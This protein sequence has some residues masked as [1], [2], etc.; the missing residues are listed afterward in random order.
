[1]LKI[2]GTLVETTEGNPVYTSM[3]YE[4]DEETYKLVND[5]FDITY[6]FGAYNQV[7]NAENSFKKDQYAVYRK[8]AEI[9]KNQ[10]PVEIEKYSPNEMAET[11]AQKFEPVEVEVS[12]NSEDGEVKYQKNYGVNVV[13]P[14]M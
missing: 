9:T 3:L 14:E 11:S 2:Y 5:S 8:V 1:M 4:I 7:I 10:H 13:M 12:Y 6:E